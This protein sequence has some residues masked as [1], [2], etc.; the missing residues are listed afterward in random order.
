MNIALLSRREN[1][2]NTGKRN[3][4]RNLKKGGGGF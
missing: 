2:T 4:L 1:D 3:R